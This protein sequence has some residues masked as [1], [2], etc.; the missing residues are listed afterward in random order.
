VSVSKGC[1][2][3]GRRLRGVRGHCLHGRRRGL[4][5]RMHTIK[6]SAGYFFL[7]LIHDVPKLVDDFTP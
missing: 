4:G 3:G 1:P 2:G 7:A 5:K 6:G